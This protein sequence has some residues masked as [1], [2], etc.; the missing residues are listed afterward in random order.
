V[1]AERATYWGMGRLSRDEIAAT[2]RFLDSV[3]THH[4]Y[5]VRLDEVRNTRAIDRFHRTG[6]ALGPEAK[7]PQP[8]GST[9]T[10]RF[11][12]LTKEQYL[13]ANGSGQTSGGGVGS[14]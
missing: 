2:Y 4:V 7:I 5:V 10:A 11:A 14:R 1:T 8:D 3:P 6:F 9:K 13:A 12:F